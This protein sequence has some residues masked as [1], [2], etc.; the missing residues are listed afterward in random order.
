MTWEICTSA[1]PA[2]VRLSAV[3]LLALALLLA[4]ACTRPR[5]DEV[6]ILAAAS[7][8]DLLNDLAPAAAKEG[9]ALRCSFGA[10]SQVRAQIEHGAP[11]DLLVSAAADDAR[12]LQEKGLT[13]PDRCHTLY[14]NHLVLVAPT[15]GFVRSL[16]DLRGRG[17]VAL[18]DP[19]VV[20]AGRYAEAS[21]RNL[22][23][24]NALEGRRIIGTDVRVVLQWVARGEVDA[25]VVYDTDRRAEP[26]RVRVVEALPDA[27][28][29]PIEYVAVIPTRAANPAGAEAFL[30][31]LASASARAAATARGF[32]PLMDG[33]P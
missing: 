4:P 24:W 15:E 30:R 25:A 19:R 1:H 22:G 31:L 16:D 2:L 28:H 32:E 12:T 20:P 11:A 14:R 18:G 33:K 5:A 7:L 8:V 9:L 23:L 17:R 6:R 26:T 13:T 3:G 29:A 27:S 21:L 10:S